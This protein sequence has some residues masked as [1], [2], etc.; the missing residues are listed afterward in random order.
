MKR[1]QQ[2]PDDPL[3]AARGKVP[4]IELETDLY[5]LLESYHSE[6]RG[7]R[8]TLLVRL[9]EWEQAGLLNRDQLADVRLWLNELDL[10]EAHLRCEFV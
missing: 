7:V 4:I 3:P 2:H 10:S 1:K 8:K 6:S 5:E 9:L